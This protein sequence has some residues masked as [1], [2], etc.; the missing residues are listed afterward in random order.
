M[1]V[2]GENV[3]ALVPPESFQGEGRTACRKLESSDLKHFSHEFQK[4]RFTFPK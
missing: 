3:K 4:A 2:R 1:G